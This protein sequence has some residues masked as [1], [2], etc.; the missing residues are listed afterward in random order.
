MCYTM[1]RKRCMMVEEGGEAME[2]E[3]CTARPGIRVP[4]LLCLVFAPTVLLMAVYVAWG[5]AGCGVPSLL[6]FS[7]LALALLLPLEL[8]IVLRAGKRE[9][10][11]YSLKSAWCAWGGQKDGAQGRSKTKT[12]LEAVGYGTAL[13]AFAGVMTATLARLEAAATSPAA[14]RLA[15]V[16]PAYFDW[17]NIGLLRQYGRGLVLATCAVYFVC[18][19]LV[20]PLVEE[21]FF[22]G[23]L[24]GRLARLGPWAPLL[25]TVLFSLYHLW[26]PFANVFRIA[27]FFPAAYLAWKKQNLLLSIV[28]HCLC[29]L[30]TTAGFILA[31]WAG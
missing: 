10:G 9:Q 16:T 25:V 19:V 2:A 6:L 20:G 23:Y 15:A 29:N 24:T 21:L 3:R 18:N 11:Y 8:G 17:E 22:R 7:L 31:V 5:L 30:F 12:W 1:E 14:Q 13:F 26:L 27:V 28:F 4:R